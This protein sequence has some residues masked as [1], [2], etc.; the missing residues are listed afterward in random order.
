MQRFAAMTRRAGLTG[1]IAGLAAA[2]Q[3]LAQQPPNPPPPPGLPPGPHPMLREAERALHHARE[4][5]EHAEHDFGGHRTR[6][7]QYVDGALVEIRQAF[8]QFPR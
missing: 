6:A 2:T 4:S 8:Q 1:L 7:L 3:A 5:L